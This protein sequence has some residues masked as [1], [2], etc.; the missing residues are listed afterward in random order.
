MTDVGF[1]I[2]IGVLTIS[3]I[4]FAYLVITAPYGIET[5]DGIHFFKTKKEMEDFIEKEKT[6]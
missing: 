5:K 6:K 1:Y 4:I 2:V 3:I